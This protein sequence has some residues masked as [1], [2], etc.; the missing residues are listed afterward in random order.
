MIEGEARCEM[1]PQKPKLLSVSLAWG[2]G[3]LLVSLGQTISNALSIPNSGMTAAYLLG[4]AGWGIGAVAT[5]RYV[6]HK[7]ATGR[8][9]IVLSAIG[10]G[11]GA[12]VA[13][14]LMPSVARLAENA[15]LG[16]LGPTGSP[17][18]GSVIGGAFTLSSKSSMS[19]TSVAGA[20]MRGA[21]SW[22]ISFLV[23]QY[24][25]FLS[26]YILLLLTA[27]RLEPIVGYPWASVPGWAIPAA[28]GGGLAGLIAPWLQGVNKIP[29]EKVPQT[30]S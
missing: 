10:W 6:H 8:S 20:V 16:F 2:I 19:R 15:M 25:A 23:F 7:F 28:F 11:I 1:R 24:L 5:I 18:L 3:W 22:G 21:L 29:E 14:V 17:I 12:F 26:G 27:T 13:V 9:A 4:F 30:I